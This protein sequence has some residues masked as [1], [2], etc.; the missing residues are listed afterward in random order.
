VIIIEV[1]LVVGLIMGAAALIPRVA[2][3]SSPPTP[4]VPT[5]VHDCPRVIA[6]CR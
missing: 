6:A 4:A 2:P 5:D 1:M 3:P